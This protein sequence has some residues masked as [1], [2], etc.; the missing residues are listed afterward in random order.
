MTLPILLLFI[1][2]LSPDPVETVD[3]GEPPNPFVVL[4]E[5]IR[6]DYD[7]PSLAAA[8][9]DSNEITAIGASGI[10]KVGDETA[11]TGDDKWHLGS[12]TKAMT[13]TLTGTLVEDGTVTWETTL[14]ELFPAITMDAGWNAVTIEMLLTHQGGV[15]PN[16]L[17]TDLWAPLWQSGD[18]L[19]QR[20]TFAADLLADPPTSTPGAGY[21]Y[22]NGGYMLVGAGLENLTGKSWET[23]IEERL[24]TPTGMTNCGFGAPAS[25]GQVDQPWGHGPD[26]VPVAPEGVSDNPPALGPAGTVHCDMASWAAFGRITLRGAQG[27]EEFLKTETWDRILTPYPGSGYA[28]GWGVGSDPQGVVY[29]HSGSNTMWFATIWVMPGIDRAFMVA[30]NTGEA[31]SFDA[32]EAGLSRIGAAGY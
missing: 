29:R 6:G 13:A 7:L 19:V 4:L 10:R 2:C 24:F 21:N 30:T 23:L 22:A 18:V 31:G 26:G 32:L 20:Q 12:D 1:G 15:H 3:T 5:D 25:A 27:K 14:P 8:V 28:Y 11:V 16:L 17:A 9:T